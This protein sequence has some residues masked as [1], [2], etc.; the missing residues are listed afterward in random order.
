MLSSLT[1][2]ILVIFFLVTVSNAQT[3]TPTPIQDNETEQIF[4]E[5]IKLNVL[6]FNDEGKFA[7]DVKKKIWLSP[8]IIFCI[9]QAALGAF[10]P[11]F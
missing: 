8:K 3:P 2:I 9:R 11:M 1:K 10:P 5:E 4:T 6:A 7:T